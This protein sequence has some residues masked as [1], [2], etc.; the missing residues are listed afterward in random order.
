MKDWEMVRRLQ[1]TPPHLKVTYA[2]GQEIEVA[3]TIYLPM[4]LRK[5]EKVQRLYETSALDQPMILG[6]DWLKKNKALINFDST[7]LKIGTE[8]IPVGTEVSEVLTLLSAEN[9]K[10]PIYTTRLI[11]MEGQYQALYQVILKSWISPTNGR[12]VRWWWKRKMGL[13]QIPIMLDNP[14]NK[15]VKM[16]KR[17]GVG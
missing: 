1:G 12:I 10:L 3:G 9:V 7:L 6:G 5:L 17:W 2:G 15:T 8:E 14:A 16:P 4:K 11:P 13:N